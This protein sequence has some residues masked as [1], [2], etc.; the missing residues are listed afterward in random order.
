MQN[1]RRALAA[2]PPDPAPSLPIPHSAFIILH[3]LMPDAPDNLPG[4]RKAAI[5]L[6]SLTQDQAAQILKRLPREQV[7]EVSREIASLQEVPLGT[8]QSIFTE[9]Y[10]LALANT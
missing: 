9:F 1:G 2:P 10:H 6:L 3:F 4:V 8:R 5:L 7:E